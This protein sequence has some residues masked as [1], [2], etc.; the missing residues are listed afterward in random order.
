MF[1]VLTLLTVMPNV[2]AVILVVA[3]AIRKCADF[4][5]VMKTVVY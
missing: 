5:I 2:F 1:G 4:A 3:S